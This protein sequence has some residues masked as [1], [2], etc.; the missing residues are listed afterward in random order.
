MDAILF[1]V[2]ISVSAVIL[3]PTL[4]ADDQ[5]RSGSYI[6]AQEMDTSLMNSIMSSTVDE[7]EYI[8]EPSELAGIDVNMSD[9][10]ILENAEKTLFTKEQHHRTFSDLVAEGLVL[11]LYQDD[12]GTRK[13][14]NPMTQMQ[15]A[16]TQD[17]IEAHLERTIGQRYN[18]RF[19]AHWQPVSGYTMCKVV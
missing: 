4:A 14:L 17:Q 8:L 3:M 5:Y 18:Y 16:K 19:E 10:S 6:S 7:F 11:G 12:N 13:V 9:N 1:L 2:F 15:S